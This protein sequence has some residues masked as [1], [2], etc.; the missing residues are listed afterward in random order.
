MLNL[1]FYQDC[2]SAIK[3]LPPAMVLASLALHGLVLLIPLSSKRQIHQSQ[4]KLEQKPILISQSESKHFFSSDKALVKQKDLTSTPTPIPTND[5]L[6]TSQLPSPP[7]DAILQTQLPIPEIATMPI[8]P[9]SLEVT[10]PVPPV[11]VN[12]SVQYKEVRQVTDG[13]AAVIVAPSSPKKQ[14]KKDNSNSIPV[15]AKTVTP[16]I[17]PTPQASPTK[18][19]ELLNQDKETFNKTL[20]QLKQE[21]GLSDE[22]NLSQPEN[23][24]ATT[25]VKRIHGVINKAPEEVAA[26]VA[27]KLEAQG[28]KLSQLDN[29]SDGIVY[30]VTKNQFTQY[31][32]FTANQGATGTIITTS[33]KSPI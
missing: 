26:S 24:S 3:R 18:A 21:L 32:T 28:F 20:N 25:G 8:L 4:A 9:P 31:I 10:P 11:V 22:A 2:W 33:L 30:A 7:Q 13:T 6:F 14:P 19:P 12:S 27:S 23:L 1:S 17:T 15:V 5:P 16:V 29:Y